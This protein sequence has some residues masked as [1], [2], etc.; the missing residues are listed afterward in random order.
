MFNQLETLKALKALYTPMA[1][2]DALR[3]AHFVDGVITEYEYTTLGGGLS[4][5]KPW[6]LRKLAYSEAS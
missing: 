4:D 5:A 2:A 6:W 1:L 3:W